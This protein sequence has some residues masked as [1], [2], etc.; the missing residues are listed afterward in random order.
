MTSFQ[1]ATGLL[2]LAAG[3]AMVA[4][5]RALAASRYPAR[6]VYAAFAADTSTDSPL[7]AECEGA[8]NGSTEDDGDGTATCPGCGTPR[9]S[10]VPDAA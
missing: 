2:V 3:I 5:A 4:A 10:P 6:A 9:R 1:I 8:C 7:V